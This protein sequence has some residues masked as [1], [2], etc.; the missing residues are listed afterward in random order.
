[1]RQKEQR[2]RQQTKRG[3]TVS[4]PTTFKGAL[5]HVEVTVLYIKETALN[6]HPYAAAWYK[7]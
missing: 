6:I 2:K 5:G 4:R 3:Q 7:I 1:M